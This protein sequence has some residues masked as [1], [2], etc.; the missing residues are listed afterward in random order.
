MY[1]RVSK[2]LTT[3]KNQ[4]ISLSRVKFHEEAKENFMHFDSS[5]EQKIIGDN[6]KNSLISGSDLISYEVKDKR[7]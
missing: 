2:R 4:H 5:E 1:L 3:R 6:F 7:F